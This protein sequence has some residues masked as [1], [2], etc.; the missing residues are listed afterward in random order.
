MKKTI[1]LVFILTALTSISHAQNGAKQAFNK[2]LIAY[3]NA[4][5]TLSKDKIAAA[6]AASILENIN[7]FPIKELT[8]AQKVLWAAQT[9]EIKKAAQPMVGEK[10]IKVQRK[11]FETISYA[12]IKLVNGLKMNNNK[13]YLQHCPMARASW[14]NE[15][16]D[17]Q[18][19]YYGSMMFDCGDVKETIAK[20]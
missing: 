19:P 15:V 18:N 4:K 13:I 10:D 16:E 11:Q 17:I 14:L 20:N 7:S 5:N 1:L 6:D 3:F 9:A 8:P 12:M 2:T